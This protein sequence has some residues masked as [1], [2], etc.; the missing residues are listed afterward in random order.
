MGCTPD[1]LFAYPLVWEIHIEV[2]PD[3]TMEIR[4]RPV[5]LVVNIYIAI[6]LMNGRHN[7]YLNMLRFSAS[8]TVPSKNYGLTGLPNGT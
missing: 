5:L 2:A 6:L 8:V 4:G 7:G 3:I 1:F